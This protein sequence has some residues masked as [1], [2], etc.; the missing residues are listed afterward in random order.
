MSPRA[1]PGSEAWPTVSKDRIDFFQKRV[2]DIKNLLRPPDVAAHITRLLRFA[3]ER[4]GA[5]PRTHRDGGRD[6]FEHPQPCD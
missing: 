2:V 4:A 6:F 3:I 1:P 5:Q